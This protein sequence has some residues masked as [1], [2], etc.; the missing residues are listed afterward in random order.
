MT[1]GLADYR[2][3]QQTERLHRM[4]LLPWSSPRGE[5]GPAE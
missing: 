4:L 3:E 5:D 2:D 1:I